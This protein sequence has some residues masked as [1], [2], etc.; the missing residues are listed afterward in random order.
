MALHR[1]QFITGVAAAAAVAGFD[2]VAGRWLSV[3]QARRGRHDEIP[4]LEGELITDDATLED[5]STDA[6]NHVFGTPNAVL[7]PASAQDIAAM[8]R[9]CVK[10][11][12]EIAAR[13]EAHSTHGQSL[14][15][16]MIDMSTLS[17]IHSIDQGEAVVD[18]G[19]TWKDLLAASLPH[20]LTPPVLTGFIGLSLGG[21]LSMGG[22]SSGYDRGAQVDHVLELEVVTGLGEIVT[23]SDTRNSQLFNAVLGGLGQ[24]GIITRAVVEL[25][26]AMPRAVTY[27][28]IYFDDASMFEDLWKLLRRNEFDDVFNMWVPGGPNGFM[29]VLNAVKYYDPSSPPDEAHLLRDLQH[30]APAMQTVDDTY[31]DY[32]LRVDH[33]VDQ[34]KAMGAWDNV[35]HPWFDVFLPGRTVE[36]YV[37]EV[38]PTLTPEDVGA[39]GFFLLFPQ[40]RSRFTR[41]SFRLPDDEWIFLFNILTA[42][43]VPGYDSAFATRMMT[44]NRDLFDLAKRHGG[45]RY[46]IGSLDFHRRDWVHHYG[47]RLPAHTVLKARFDPRKILT[48]G[49]DI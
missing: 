3:A 21:T 13:G 46:P 39:A 9:Y 2:P 17:T 38:M 18:A 10:H 41:P 1:R 42:R 30:V 40:R 49:L 28:L 8:I 15:T 43:S 16:L 47:R 45:V 32:A 22:I 12:S 25:V 7:R 36:R 35:M 31:H 27:Q 34:F 11:R 37:S 14:A 23:C 5:Y 48:P 19:A 26:P 6:G 29:S 33:A 20:G 44:R 4:S 24:F